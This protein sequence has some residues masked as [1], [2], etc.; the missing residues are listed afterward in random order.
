[1]CSPPKH[2]NEHS[3][4]PDKPKQRLKTNSFVQLANVLIGQNGLLVMNHSQLLALNVN[5]QDH[6]HAL[7]QEINLP[8]PPHALQSFHQPQLALLPNVLMLKDLNAVQD[9]RLLQRTMSAAVHQLLIW[10]ALFQLNGNQW[11]LHVNVHWKVKFLDVNGDG[12][13]L[14]LLNATVL[15]D[16]IPDNNTGVIPIHKNGPNGQPN[17]PHQPTNVPTNVINTNTDA[18][19][20]TVLQVLV[21]LLNMV[22]K[23]VNPLLPRVVCVVVKL[24]KLNNQNVTQDVAKKEPSLS[25]RPINAEIMLLK[26]WAQHVLMIS[27]LLHVSSSQVFQFTEPAVPAALVQEPIATKLLSTKE[28]FAKQEN[29][30]LLISP[31][32][33]M[34]NV[35]SLLNGH[36]A[37]K[38]L[39][40]F[41]MRIKKSNTFVETQFQIIVVIVNSVLLHGPGLVVSMLI[42]GS[43]IIHGIILQ[44]WDTVAS[45]LMT[46]TDALVSANKFVNQSVKMIH[47]WTTLQMK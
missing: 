18:K 9:W 6:V 46:L 27:S 1:M 21:V 28:L 8:K 39:K 44:P 26:L 34:V 43:I 41:A 16:Q 19:L 25:P 12:R 30:S 24:L 2:I 3:C 23:H 47:Q 35:T 15:N 13:S 14:P 11:Q 38:M 31:V 29:A 40:D 37:N 20:A 7:A 36:H 4:V 33:T 5:D 10:T 42:H 17:G 45:K 32:L 22:R